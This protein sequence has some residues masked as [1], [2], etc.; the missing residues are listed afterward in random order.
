VGKGPYIELSIPRNPQY[1]NLYLE[2]VL[3]DNVKVAHTT[4][5]TPFE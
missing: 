5:N 1:Y 4:L 2:A 3:G